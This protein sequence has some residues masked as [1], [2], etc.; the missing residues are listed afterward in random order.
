MS[1]S[2]LLRQAYYDL[3]N[4]ISVEVYKDDAPKGIGESHVI[5]SVES[6]PDDSTRKGFTSYPIVITE[7]VGI[8]LNSVDPDVVDDIETEIQ[9]ILLPTNGAIAVQAS[10]IGINLI[11]KLD[12]QYISEDDGKKRYLRKII[13]WQQRVTNS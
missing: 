10:G 1:N 2:K 11:R 8:F 6:E 12:S 4:G 5:V 7:I 3:L 9:N 13:R